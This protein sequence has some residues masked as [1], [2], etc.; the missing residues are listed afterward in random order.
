MFQQRFEKDDS[1]MASAAFVW[2]EV[3][4]VTCSPLLIVLFFLNSYFIHGWI[5]LTVLARFEL[6]AKLI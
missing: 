2:L 3:E 1:D 5:Y 4:V 6:L